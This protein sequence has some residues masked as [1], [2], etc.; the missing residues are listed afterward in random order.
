MF[1]GAAPRNRAELAES[2]PYTRIFL[3]FQSANVRIGAW[4]K[5]C[6]DGQASMAIRRSPF[7]ASISVKKGRSSAA[8]LRCS[9]TGRMSGAAPP[10]ARASAARAVV[11]QVQRVMGVSSLSSIRRPWPIRSPWPLIQC[12]HG[13][14]QG[15]NMHRA[16]GIVARC[17]NPLT[18]RPHAIR[19]VCIMT[20][21]AMENAMTGTTLRWGL[22]SVLVSGLLLVIG[23]G[24][25]A[26][27]QP[28]MRDLELEALREAVRWPD[29]DVITVIALTGRFVAARQDQEGLAYFEERAKSVPRRPLFV[30]LEGFFQARVADDVFLLRRIA[31][32]N[33]AVA[34]L[35]RAVAQEAGLPRY[36]RGLVLAELP[37]RFGKAAAAVDDLQWVLD[38][39]DRFPVGLRRSVYRGLAKAYTTLGREAEA[40]AALVRSGYPS[41]D[42]TL[43]VFTTDNW[44][45]AKDGFRFR[46]PRLVELAPRVY[47][48]QGYD[49][50]DI[51]FV[52]TDDGIVAI[53]AGT[54]EANAR[55]ALAAL[56]RITAAP[57]T[58]VLVTHA[59]WDHIGGLPALRGASTKVVAN[60]RFADELKI[61]N[62]TGVG[63]SE[64][65]TS[66][67]Q[68]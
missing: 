42:P 17:L 46:P 22:A 53:D 36:F 37:A 54:T 63:R 2:A 65:H 64:E 40:N 60:A 9:P 19:C 35:D 56:R 29:P 51:A 41:L 48:A 24:P 50:A 30:A 18:T 62:D 55:V 28:L 13:A 26:G 3:P 61:V 21:E 68:S 32:V 15:R 49:F 1:T 66:E 7:L 27:E 45:T 8:A 67:L 59:H 58:H 33:D 43:P 44:V 14:C 47:V 12:G 10:A 31:W 6:C 11:I 5:T 52:V 34:K 23:A 39:K 20:G 4:A 57:I 16:L 25:V 38:N